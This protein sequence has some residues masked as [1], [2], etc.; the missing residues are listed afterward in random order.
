MKRGSWKRRERERKME[1]KRRV[2]EGEEE[3][4]LKESTAIIREEK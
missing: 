1:K 3:G 4:T 2:Q